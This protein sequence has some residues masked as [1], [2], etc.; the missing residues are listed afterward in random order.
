MTQKRQPLIDRSLFFYN[1]IQYSIY[2]KWCVCLQIFHICHPTWRRFGDKAFPVTATWFHQSIAS[3]SLSNNSDNPRLLST[4]NTNH[5]E[6]WQYIIMRIYPGQQYPDLSYK[7]MFPG[8]TFE[9]THLIATRE[10]DY[11]FRSWGAG[12]LDGF[13]SSFFSVF[14]LG[15]FTM[16]QH[17]LGDKMDYES[18]TC[19][20]S[21]YW[22]VGER[23]TQL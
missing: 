9:T 17:P 23:S 14:L 16:Y 15:N 10:L 11:L 18:L 3:M 13:V 6:H 21:C 1:W 4:H 12:P 5:L 19:L 20:C 8:V 7:H 2:D 22:M